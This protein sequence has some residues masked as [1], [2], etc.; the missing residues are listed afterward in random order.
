MCLDTHT[1][2]CYQCCA[3]TL[4]THLSAVW[5]TIPQGPDANLLLLSTPEKWTQPCANPSPQKVFPIPQS[6]LHSLSPQI[7]RLSPPA[8]QPGFGFSG[9]WQTQLGPFS[10]SQLALGGGPRRL[11][12]APEGFPSCSALGSH[13]L[14]SPLPVSLCASPILPLSL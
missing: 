8:H 10:L 14:L 11:G 1:H 4:M 9:W 12:N 5:F 7:L 3:Q 6:Q 2:I 13:W